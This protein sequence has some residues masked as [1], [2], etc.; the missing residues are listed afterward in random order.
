MTQLTRREFLGVASLGVAA[1][2]ATACSRDEIA[3]QLADA[4]PAMLTLQQAATAVF[5]RKVSSVALTEACLERITKFDGKL[6]SFI[7]VAADDALNAARAADKELKDGK[8]RGPL[9]GIPIGLKDNID[10]A[11]LLTTAGS[12]LYEKRIPKSDA[13]VVQ[14]LRDAGAVVVGKLNMHEFALGTTSAISHYGA[15]HNPW[16][17]E[18]VAGGSSGGCGAAVA[19]N[20]VFGAVGTDTGGSIRV[21]ASACGIVGLKPTYDVVSSE[22]VVPISRSFDHV[23]PMCR[24]ANDTALM[25]RVMTDNGASRGY[26]AFSPPNFPKP[27]LGVVKNTA[28]LCERA[29]EAE[30]Q[31]IFDRAVDA[32]RPFVASSFDVD[33]PMPSEL[34]AI[35]DAE[36][37]AY[38]QQHAIASPELY[39]ARTLASIS[40]GKNISK[41][42]RDSLKKALDKHR[43]EMAGAFMLVDVAV[44]PTL[45]TLP[46]RLADATTPF[47]QGSCTFEYSQAGLPSLSIPCGISSSGLPVGM[48]ISSPPFTEPRLFALAAAYEK[49]TKWHLMH[50]EL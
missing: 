37:W 4:G 11:N 14:K 15:V 31:E 23:G 2:S 43:Y 7:T 20:F 6:N 12:A 48:L 39:D 36:A 21:P 34:G 38:H 1:L 35:I 5:Q 32:L 25:F 3:E 33:L 17:V 27:R 40:N 47:A 9:H 41:V 28:L 10:T 18:Y 13:V 16:N 8:W 29:V 50:P 26:D 45:P 19:A 42:H 30:V 46:I 49:A 44:H 24:T 22:G